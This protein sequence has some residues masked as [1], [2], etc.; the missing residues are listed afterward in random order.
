MTVTSGLWWSV[1]WPWTIPWITAIAAMAIATTVWIRHARARKPTS[2][3]PVNEIIY[4]KYGDAGQ[5]PV[6]VTEVFTE[7]RGASAQTTSPVATVVVNRSGG[8]ETSLVRKEDY[9]KIKVIE[10][11]KELESSRSMVHVDLDKWTVTT[12]SPRRRSM[13]LSALG[14]VV[15]S[16]RFCRRGDTVL[17][18]PYGNPA[19][20]EA[21]HIRITCE[22]GKLPANVDN[23]FHAS[24]LGNI[25]DWDPKARE[26]KLE[27][28][29]IFR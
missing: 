1:W 20:G 8:R 4:Y 10:R 12:E 17:M 21:A 7:N 25:G 11:I 23:E 27:P 18:V 16:G 5:Q 26:L 28:E 29:A 24:C 19:N 14:E 2:V 6:D 13:K 9:R 3:P 15:I 22:A